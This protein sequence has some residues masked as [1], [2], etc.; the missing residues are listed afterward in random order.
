MLKEESVQTVHSQGMNISSGK[1]SVTL[2]RY[3]TVDNSGSLF[4]AAP[5]TIYSGLS[6]P[7][8]VN[9]TL[10]APQNFFNSQKPEFQEF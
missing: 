2:G 10:R 6:Y 9:K 1:G 8:T 3:C 7:L 4:R 5:S